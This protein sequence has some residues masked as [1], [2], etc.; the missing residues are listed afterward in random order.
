LNAR[1]KIILLPILLFSFINVLS[2][3][4]YSEKVKRQD[5]A[6]HYE[7]NAAAEKAFNSF[8]FVLRSETSVARAVQAYFEGSHF[9]SRSELRRFA[10]IVLDDKPEVQALNWLPRIEH[11]QRASFEQRIQDEGFKNYR[12]MDHSK[13]SGLIIA[14]EQ[15]VYFPIKYYEPAALNK[16]IHLLNTIS[17]EQSREAVN[18]IVDGGK[19]YVVSAPFTLVQEAGEQQGVLMFF[20]VYKQGKLL[21]L[22]EVVLRMGSFL[23]HIE[24]IAGEKNHL[25]IGVS[26]I[27][28]GRRQALV[29][30]PAL[31]HLRGT[32]LY[33]AEDVAIGGRIWQV[34]A[35][36]TAAILASHG[37]ES[38]SFLFSL[39]KGPLV[40]LL[41]S[42]LLGFSLYQKERAE[43]RAQQL[44]ESESRFKQVINMS[45]DAYYLFD[46]EGH[47]L[48]VNQQACR[49][50]GY[51]RDELLA[52]KSSDIADLSVDE[53][54]ILFAT[55]Q[56]GE[57]KSMD[58]RHR[59]KTGNIL[60]VEVSISH[61]MLGDKPV[62]SVF[63]R[64][65]SARVKR[66]NE[67][68]KSQHLLEQAQKWHT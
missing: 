2:Y 45:A 36:P 16:Q 57:A 43:K 30:N 59:H 5:D 24:L 51:S 48:D 50:V 40:G 27:T 25:E 3:L 22:V 47:V 11:A 58:C 8:T 42:G 39:V 20:P 37:S 41:V 19:E 21:G 4:N 33:Q 1:L 29:V 6:I 52:L 26:D 23:N 38:R 28:G 68:R 49:E 14:V 17:I 15:D 46:S 64:D 7:F 61:F 34:E 18:R 31:E 44:K 67:L 32:H 35:F 13:D 60:P 65:I 53:L 66:E 9:V 56:P 63:S 10:E 55:F 62:Y 12:I 54:T